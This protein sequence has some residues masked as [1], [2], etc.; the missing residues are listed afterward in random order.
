MQIPLVMSVWDDGYGIS[1]PREF[2][3]TK[4]SISE[5]L[6]GMQR[7]EDKKGYEIF[8]TKGW[9]YAH[10]CQTY[11]KAVQIARE[12][13]VPVLIH[14]KEVN[15][16]QGHSTSGSHE[17]YKTEERLIWE[18]NTT[19]SRNLKNGFLHLRWMEIKLPMK[20]H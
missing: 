5:A 13:H 11:K 8:V 3:T 16:P 17:R 20:K 14:V 4:G 12:E 18:K 9:D 1:V 7:T 10:L 15:Q 19:A 6:A 2:Q